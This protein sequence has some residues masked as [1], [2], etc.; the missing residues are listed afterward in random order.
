MHFISGYIVFELGV[1]KMG[2]IRIYTFST[3]ILSVYTH[4]SIFLTAAFLLLVLAI[5]LLEVKS[6]RSKDAKG[7]WDA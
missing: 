6:G 1:A 3:H 5:F 4:I 7:Y 2:F